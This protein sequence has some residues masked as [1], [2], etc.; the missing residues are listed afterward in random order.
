MS[1][2]IDDFIKHLEEEFE[3][4]IQPGTLKPDTVLEKAIALTSVNALILISMIKVEYD[5][6]VNA[7]DL[8][9]CKTINDLFN[10]INKKLN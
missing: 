10:V 6:E 4:D 9:K 5:V 7:N 1:L 3:D 8:N 2:N